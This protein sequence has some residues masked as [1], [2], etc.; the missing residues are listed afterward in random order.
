ML[1]PVRFFVTPWTIVH[2]SPLSL[3]SSRQEYWS[4]LSVPSPRDLTTSEI[5]P[6]PL[7]SP[8]MIG[9]FFPTALLRKRGSFV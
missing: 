4:G 2:H 9:G 3:E 7:A 1:S 8:A 5:E 6:K